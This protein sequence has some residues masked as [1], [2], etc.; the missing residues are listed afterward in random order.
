[1]MPHTTRNAAIHATPA[2]RMIIMP[3]RVIVWWGPRLIP[4][5]AITEPTAAIH[6]IANAVRVTHLLAASCELRFLC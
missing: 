1:M 4:A 2:S 6:P 3:N 5:R